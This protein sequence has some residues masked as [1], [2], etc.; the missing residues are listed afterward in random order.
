MIELRV[1]C[2]D[3]WAEIEE[4]HDACLSDFN[5]HYDSEHLCDKCQKKADVLAEF[6]SWVEREQLLCSHL[7]GFEFRGELWGSDGFYAYNH[8]FLTSEIDVAKKYVAEVKNGINPSNADLSSM[9]KALEKILDANEGGRNFAEY[10][11]EANDLTVFADVDGKKIYAQSRYLEPIKD[12]LKRLKFTY[13][14][15]KSGDKPVLI[16]DGKDNL[17]GIVMSYIK[18]D[19]T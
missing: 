13:K 16:F 9:A 5:E 7:Y 14:G 3:C 11:T 18:K 1:V 10:G 8:K 12:D 15:E 19:L 4:I 2:D 17:I 6:P